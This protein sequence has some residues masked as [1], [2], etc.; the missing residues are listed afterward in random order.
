MSTAQYALPPTDISSV[1]QLRT[2]QSWYYSTIAYFFLMVFCMIAAQLDS[3]L[4]FD[5]SVVLQRANMIV[6]WCSCQG[7][8]TNPFLLLC[9][10]TFD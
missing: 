4:L 3:R 7:A 2:P 8:N 10:K 9:S 6:S 1:W 5:V